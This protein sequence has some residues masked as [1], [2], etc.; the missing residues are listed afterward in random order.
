LA[1]ALVV[2]GLEAAR[3]HLN[4]KEWFLPWWLARDADIEPNTV[5]V[6]VCHGADDPYESKKK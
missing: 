1:I 3:G 2:L 6:L 4:L 5:P